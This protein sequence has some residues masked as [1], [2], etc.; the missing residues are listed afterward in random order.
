MAQVH[1]PI[2]A[3]RRSAT[4]DDRGIFCPAELWNQIT[5]RLM[6]NSAATILNG[7]P[8]NLQDVLRRA[9]HDRPWSLRPHGCDND[10]RQ[11]VEHWCK[12]EEP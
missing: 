10:L 3:I 5:D 11:E 1:D 9:Y 2:E 8:T 7:L 4:L 12:R 6:V